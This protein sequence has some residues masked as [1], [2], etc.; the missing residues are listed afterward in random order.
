M[1]LEYNLGTTKKDPLLVDG[2]RWPDLFAHEFCLNNIEYF[3][4]HLAR[5]FPRKEAL[6]NMQA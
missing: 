3:K 2:Y 4:K 6:N 5:P 1:S